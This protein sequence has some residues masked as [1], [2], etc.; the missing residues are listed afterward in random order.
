[1]QNQ[2]TSYPN[3]S[4][5]ALECGLEICKGIWGCHNR[6]GGGRYQ[7]VIVCWTTSMQQTY[8]IEY[9][10]TFHQT[11][12]HSARPF[13]MYPRHK[14]LAPLCICQ[15]IFHFEVL[16]P[17]KKFQR[18]LCEKQRKIILWYR[19]NFT[20]TL[21]T[22]LEKSCLRNQQNTPV[23]AVTFVFSYCVVYVYKQMTTSLYSMVNI[24]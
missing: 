21:Y 15:A 6:W 10:A 19:Q 22:R 8:T 2:K 16:T 9:N 17:T 20:K 1:M 13:L 23:A 18:L 14:L 5:W 24:F 3:V 12:W 11:F 4:Q 7:H